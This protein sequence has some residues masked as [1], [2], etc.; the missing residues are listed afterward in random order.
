LWRLRQRVRGQSRVAVTDEV[1]RV[2]RV[3]EPSRAER[4]QSESDRTDEILRAD[5]TR[6]TDPDSD[7]HVAAVAGARVD[8]WRR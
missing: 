4:P 2:Q 6:N 3:A 1:P 7:S 8:Q 5:A